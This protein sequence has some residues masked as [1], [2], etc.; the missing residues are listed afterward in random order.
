MDT[1]W[2]LGKF[3]S[4]IFTR[5]TLW[6]KWAVCR[7]LLQVPCNFIASWPFIFCKHCRL[8]KMFC[9]AHR[10]Y[11]SPSYH[12]IPLI[13]LSALDVGE[14][15]APAMPPTLSLHYSPHNINLLPPTWRHTPPPPPSASMYITC[16]RIGPVCV[17]HLMNY[18]HCYQKYSHFLI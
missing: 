2:H 13:A 15:T 9:A 14:A 1:T 4:M 10:T 7:F 6:F 3:S 18:V 5:R 17:C 11:P 8:L 12:F 16:F